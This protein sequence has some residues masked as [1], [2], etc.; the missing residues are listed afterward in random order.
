MNFDLMHPADQLV[1][2]MDRI[3]GFGM[4]TTTGGNLSVKDSDG[5]VWIT[6]S[7][8]DKGNLKRGDIIEVKP[9]GTVIGPHKPSVEL[10]FHLH[11]YESRSDIRAILHAHPPALVGYAALRK[12][13]DTKIM[14]N[15]TFTCGDV[16]Q[17]GYAL[18][19][20][21]KLGDM[22]AKEFQKGA[23]MV[24]MDNHGVVVGSDNLFQAFKMFETLDYCARIHINAAPLGKVNAL[25]DEQLNQYYTR[26]YPEMEEFY[27]GEYSSEERHYR[28][29]M[30][31][32]ILRAYKQQLFT[33]TQG[34][35]SRRLSDGSFIIT[36]YGKDRMYLEPEDLVNIRQ[37]RK[38]YGKRPSRAV[39]L[40]QAIYDAHP[41]IMSV[42]IAH[43]PNIMAFGVTGQTFDA[44]LIPESYIAL[45][46]VQ[47]LPYGTNFLNPVKVVDTMSLKQ[48]VAIVE[49]DCVLMVGTGLLNTF[50]RLEVLEYSAKSIIAASQL[51]DIV[52]ISND[53]V[54]EIEVAFNL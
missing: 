7:G 45:K 15:V 14:A 49:N 20:S 5:N 34:T 53:E 44:R 42:A 40:H 6:P 25:S 17:A 50:D 47:R 3:Y 51:G 13:P 26:Q 4:T 24:M 22:I 43:P 38:E 33:S 21:T 18:P 36:P 9:D 23:S 11:I 54:K 8:I 39:K 10:P 28:R 12:I 1:M 30:C 19:G 48:P 35:F 27:P 52:H 16:K 37:G 41:D 31:T 32:L 46:N 29:E 2:M